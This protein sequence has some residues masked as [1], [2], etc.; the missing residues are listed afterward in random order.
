MSSGPE[1]RSRRAER[2]LA[3]ERAHRRRQL[4]LLGGLVVVAL[5]GA[6][7]LILVNRPQ[8]QAGSNQPALVAG[9]AIASSIP[10]NGRT[11][12]NPSAK[13]TVVEWGDYQ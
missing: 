8:G 4:F 3:E 11:M 1:R 6:I 2:R 10:L 5:T 9:P 13:V 7:A 12:G